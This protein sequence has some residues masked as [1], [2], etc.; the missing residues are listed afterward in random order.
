MN[1]DFE[2]AFEAYA[3]TLEGAAA[4][5]NAVLDALIATLL[6]QFPPMADP[7]LEMLDL[8]EDHHR[9]QMGHDTHIAHASLTKHLAHIR[10]LVEHVKAQ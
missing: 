4:A 9:L 3:Q 8:T 6:K 1:E 2:N 5:Q 7:F 10:E